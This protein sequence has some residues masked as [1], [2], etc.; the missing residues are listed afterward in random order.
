MLQSVS[1]WSWEISDLVAY[2][3]RTGRFK[4]TM[5]LRDKPDDEALLELAKQQAQT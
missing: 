5:R 1:K 2:A 4:A 3:Q